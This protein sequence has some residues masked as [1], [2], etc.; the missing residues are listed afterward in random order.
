MD[1]SEYKHVVLGLIFLK[2][3]SDAFG[4][5]YVGEENIQPQI[6][7]MSTKMSPEGLSGF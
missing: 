3:I 1:A 5:V 4:E 7:R 6:P 2:Y